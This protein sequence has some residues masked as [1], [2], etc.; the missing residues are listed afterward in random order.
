MVVG[1]VDGQA[2][3]RIER[4]G[5]RVVAEGPDHERVEATIAKVVDGVLVEHASDPAAD[6]VGIEIQVR[7][8]AG[9][10][11]GGSQVSFAGEVV[12]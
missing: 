7:Q 3:A 6:D 8:L 9:T 1:D 4:R 5:S 2:H 12:A 10:S 11:G